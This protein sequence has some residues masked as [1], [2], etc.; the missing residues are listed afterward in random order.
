M[1]LKAIFCQVLTREMNAVISRS[2]HT[3][4]AEAL[5]MGLHDLGSGMRV[6]LQ[7]SVDAADALGYDAIV[8]GYALCGR[9]TESIRA[10]QTQ[11]VMPRAHD[12]IGLLMGDRHI[13]A[14]YFA[15]HPGVYYRSPG[16]I[17]YQT[18]DKLL[19]P[20]W[21]MTSRTLGERRSREELIAQYG[22]ENG[23]Y[24]FQQFTAYRRH[25]SGLTYISTSV[26]SNEACREQ[27]RAEAKKEG[28][29]FEE[30]SGS[31]SLLERLV[32]G[33]WDECDFLVLPPGAQVVVT[34]DESIVKAS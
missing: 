11:I 30:V 19:E 10:G 7:R 15:Q 3:I 6:H 33:P 27:A 22:E 26:E 21:A 28:W 16:W 4:D 1:R 14:D 12:C 24:L 32:N 23:E 34:L 25:Y 29:N 13:Y 31:L 18:P 8:L 17:E 2:A 5:T 20:G 9:G